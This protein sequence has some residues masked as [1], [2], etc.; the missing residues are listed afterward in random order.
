MQFRQVRV[1]VLNTHINSTS[2]RPANRL[3]VRKHIRKKKKLREKI[4]SMYNQKDDVIIMT[5]IINS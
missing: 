3:N 4:L 1:Y 5:S 2:Q